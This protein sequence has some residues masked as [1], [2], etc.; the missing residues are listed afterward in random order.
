MLLSPWTDL[1]LTGESHATRASADPLLTT[2]GMPALVRA[3]L[4]DRDPRTPLA[5]PLYAELAGLPPLF[6]QVGDDEVLLDDATRIAR[7]AE[8][9]S[10]EVTLEVWEGMWHVFQQTAARVPE[11]REAVQRIAEFVKRRLAAAG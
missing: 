4:G 5:S 7:R 9:A 3:Y 2:E 11:A 1:A 8:A 10:V 6:V